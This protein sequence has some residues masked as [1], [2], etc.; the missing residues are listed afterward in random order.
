MSFDEEQRI[1]IFEMVKDGSMTIEEAH[2]EVKKTN[3]KA[4]EVKYIGSA[5]CAAKTLKAT[6]SDEL[7]KEACDTAV[8]RLKKSKPASAKVKLHCSTIAIKIVDENDAESSA[9]ILENEPTAQIAYAS[10]LSSDK[11]RVAYVT[12]YSRL[13][14]VWV[15]IF[16]CGKAAEAALIAETIL[17]RKQQAL[18]QKSL[19]PATGI[20]Q[21]SS[22]VD[23][24][25][26]EEE[27]F[28]PLGVFNVQYLGNVSVPDIQG[29]EIVAQAV[30][31]IK[32]AVTVQAASKRKAS[33]GS[34]KG[35]I[36]DE[37]A[38]EGIVNVPVVLVI[39][40]EGIRTVEESTHDLLYNVIIKAVSY[41]TE[42]VGKKIELF[43]FIEVD[44]RRNTKTCHV[45]LCEKGSKGQALKICDAVCE[46]FKVAVAEAKAR[47]GNPLL[48]MGRVREKVEG[49]LEGVQ[50]SR[51]GL[52][53]IKAI[54]AGQFG[55]VYLASSA[56]GEELRAVKMLRNGA[57][58]GDK[59]EFLREAETMHTMG[60]HPNLVKFAG[61]AV[62]Q[63]PWLVILEFCQYG[64]L[65][66]VLKALARR[67]VPLTTQE[68]LNAGVQLSRG[69]GYLASKRFVHMD[70]AARNVLVGDEGVL[71]VADFGLTHAFDA[72]E[73]YYKQL[74]VLKLS[75]RWLAI[76]SFD[77]KLFSEKSDVWSWAV[78][79]WEVFSYGL[80][81]YKGNKLPEV[82][83][84]VRGGHRLEQPKTCPHDFF[85]LMQKCWNIDRFKRPT[86]AA[87]TTAIDAMVAQEAGRPL[88]DIGKLLNADLNKQIRQTSIRVKSKGKVTAAPGGQDA[89]G[90]IGAVDMSTSMNPQQARPK[91]MMIA[92]LD[93]AE[94]ENA[95]GLVPI[96][97]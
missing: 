11:K 83:R 27:N 39:S 57:T 21:M 56:E 86:F 12:S 87:L 45:Y 55:K 15:H 25:E 69:L 16:Q 91:S 63:R 97:D 77:H 47:A 80:Q 74:G 24:D 2:A 32:H 34:L 66:D 60:I 49:P 71:K 7:G 22:G 88:R 35:G 92:A 41:S 94:F 6:L 28:A 3:P 85:A 9:V 84:M 46:A 17:A 19:V 8:K 89:H 48:P 78:C 52:T 20:E 36:V 73:E 82:L 64:D 30:D 37:E 93:A 13:G 58:S 38:A 65:S 23:D 50:I 33:K 44:D 72:G 51:K 43:A 31:R 67:R 75:I 18:E 68:Q 59:Q 96:P 1:A 76:D 70:I 61:V 4:F 90:L 10:V 62:Q 79:M 5:P 53:A 95:P 54:G 42:I 81:P 40:S 29:D 14:L 26:D